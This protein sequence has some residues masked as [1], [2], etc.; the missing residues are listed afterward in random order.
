MFR[1]LTSCLFFVGVF[2][3]FFGF[4]NNT[5][6]Q[7]TPTTQTINAEILSNIWYSTTTV[8]EKDIIK[9]YA[10]FQNHSDKDLSGTAGFYVDDIEIYKSD[11]T[12]SPKSLIK[13]EA[14]YIAVRG[15]HKAQA[16][17]LSI[18]ESQTDSTT[19]LS[20]G[21]LLASESEKNSFDVK[22]QITPQ[23]ILDQAG[24]IAN[25]VVNTTNTYANKLANYVD[26]LKT[27]TENL[28]STTTP[29]LNTKEPLQGEVLG[30]S[31]KAVIPNKSGFSFYNTFL[32]VL[33]F[34][35]R[36]WAWVLG[37]IFLIIVYS[38]IRKD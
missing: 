11:F 18:K 28:V 32:S 24:D 20:V 23:T 15:T 30:T 10:G 25:T 37:V 7:T 1:R 12:A 6:A 34:L 16:K 3:I 21:N 27:P 2:L 36:H 29:S 5:F 8:N 4:Y 19:T 13:L 22:Y 14:S 9:I 35:I 26:S 38:M 31:T 33:S 17:I